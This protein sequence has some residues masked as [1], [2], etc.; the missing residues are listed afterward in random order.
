MPNEAQNVSHIFIK[1]DGA[2]LPPDIQPNV[3]EVIVDQNAHLPDMFT[4][5]VQD[6][7]DSQG[8]RF[9]VT[10]GDTFELG[11]MVKI[12]SP[13][14]TQE[15]VPTSDKVTL[16]EGEITA[17]EPLFGESMV[18]ELLVRGYDKSHRSY[19]ESKSMAFLNV[20]DKKFAEEAATAAG[21]SL[22]GD[23][24]ETVYDHIFQN[25]QS[26]LSFLIQRAWRIGY[27]CYVEDGKLHF[28]KPPESG[29]DCTLTYGQ[30]LA[31]FSPR[32]TVAEQVQEVV[33]KG[34]DPVKKEAIVGQSKS[35]KLYA[36]IGNSKNGEQYAKDFGTSKQ[37]IVDHPVHSQAEANAIATARMNELSGSF[38]EA[39]GKAHRKPEIRAGKRVELKGLGERF[40][41]KYL[42]TSAAHKWN[43][44]AIF[45]TDFVVSGT[46]SGTFIDRLTKQDPVQRWNGVVPAVVTNTKDPD[47]WGRVKLKYPWMDE[48]QESWWARIV[49]VGAG[50]DSGMIAVPHVNDE[51]LVAFEQG[52]FNRPYVLGGL[53]NG[54]DKPPSDSTGAAQGEIEKVRVWRSRTGHYINM[55]DNDDNKIEIKTAGGHTITMDDKNKKFEIKSSKGMTL[56]VDDNTQKVQVKGGGEFIIES[57]GNMNLSTKGDLTLAAMNITLDAKLALKASGLTLEAEG[58]TN[59]QLKGLNVTVQGDV[60]TRISGAMVTIN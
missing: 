39:Q 22:S 49:S 24:P 10:D 33:V 47:K 25:N 58:K 44:G 9:D 46:H 54:K 12:E 57:K 19:R 6:T 8:T 1:I 60:M 4:I 27:E 37:I 35:G 42:V 38:V 51:V 18:T 28:R 15:Q 41:G 31:S 13:K 55:Y 53:W 36:E 40:S 21:L 32:L 30:E 34:W 3:K 43:G 7:T 16:I 26:P 48:H 11:K 5:L 17:L 2:D 45:T 52:D 56:T 59:A 20:K 29:S 50:G 23:T 14:Y